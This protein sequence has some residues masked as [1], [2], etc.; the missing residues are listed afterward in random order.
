MPFE[1]GVHEEEDKFLNDFEGAHY[2]DNQMRWYV[3]RGQNFDVV[4]PV[5]FGF[6]QSLRHAPKHNTYKVMIYESDDTTAPPRRTA[7]VKPL[8]EITIQLEVNYDDLPESIDIYGQPYKKY[9]Y[10]VEMVREDA[11][12]QFFLVRNGRRLGAQNI[13]VQMEVNPTESGPA[14]ALGSR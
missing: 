2:A 10:Q 14:W 3:K 7:S 4:Q 5:K 12:L 1:E 11:G 9:S 13:A 6:S 8:C